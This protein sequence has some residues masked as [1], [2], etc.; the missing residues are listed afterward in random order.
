MFLAV[1]FI[2]LVSGQCDLVIS[3]LQSTE[4]DCETFV[5]NAQR[6][7]DHDETVRRY[8]GRC[9]LLDAKGTV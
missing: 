9:F 2:C 4:R 1:F 8:M 3:P 5:I 7:L 6:N